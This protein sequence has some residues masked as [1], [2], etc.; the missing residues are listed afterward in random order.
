MRISLRIERHENFRLPSPDNNIGG[1]AEMIEKSHQSVDIHIVI[2]RSIRPKQ[3]R[4]LHRQSIRLPRNDLF[5][6]L[7]TMVIAIQDINELHM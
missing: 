7:R 4:G 3:S 2:A 5:L 1:M 6:M